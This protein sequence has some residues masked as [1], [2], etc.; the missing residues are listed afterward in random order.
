MH[1]NSAGSVTWAD[2]TL[3]EGKVLLVEVT[4]SIASQTSASGFFVRPTRRTR[5]W[6][7]AKVSSSKASFYL[8]ATGQF[9]VEFAS[10]EFWRSDAALSFDALMLFVNPEYMIPTSGMTVIS[11]DTNKL[12]IDLGPN[13]AY[14][15][16]AGMCASAST[17]LLVNSRMLLESQVRSRA[18]IRYT[19][20]SFPCAVT[21]LNRS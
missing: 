17:S 9:S 7:K 14:L 21:V 12:A 1:S 11:P 4:T 10:Q 16:T 5:E 2:L 18:C 20:V 15:F 3:P 13:K 19:A 8:A 6:G